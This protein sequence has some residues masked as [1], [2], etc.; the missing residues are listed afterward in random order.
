MRRV[1]LHKNRQEIMWRVGGPPDVRAR[2][3]VYT[4]Y[5]TASTVFGSNSMNFGQY[6]KGGG[7]VWF[8][9]ALKLQSGA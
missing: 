8:Q 7:K 2:Q 6:R 3:R 9:K 5:V 1:V 4:I